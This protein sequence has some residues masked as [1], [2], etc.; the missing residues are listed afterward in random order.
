MGEVWRGIHREQEISV[1]IKV[2]HA[3]RARHQQYRRA[4]T[5]EVRAFAA[6]NH[7]GIV[8]VF[9]YG[10]ITQEAEELSNRQLVAEVPAA[11]EM[12][13]DLVHRADRLDGTSGAPSQARLRWYRIFRV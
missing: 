2:M 6:L 13:G 1:A 5:N 4:F 9:D 7:P 11:V 8:M 12:C 10:T 3:A